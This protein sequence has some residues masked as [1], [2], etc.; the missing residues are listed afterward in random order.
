MCDLQVWPYGNAH[1]KRTNLGWEFTCQHGGDEC[2]GNAVESC[3]K[4]L[5]SDHMTML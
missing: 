5:I 3:A 4:N 1:E 2:T